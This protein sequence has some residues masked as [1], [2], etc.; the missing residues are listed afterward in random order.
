[1]KAVV[2]RLHEGALPPEVVRAAAVVHRDSPKAADRNQID[3]GVLEVRTDVVP[4]PPGRAGAAD[5]GAQNER[6]PAAELADLVVR[7]NFGQ[8]RH[9]LESAEEG[10]LGGIFESEPEGRVIPD[11]FRRQIVVAGPFAA[12]QH[13]LGTR[14]SG[15]LRLWQANRSVNVESNESRE[16]CTFQC[17]TQARL[18]QLR[19]NSTSNAALFRGAAP[20]RP[21][22]Q[23]LPKITLRHLL[24]W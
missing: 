10:S 20:H 18:Q 24:A 12:P 7:A 14:V 19:N 21:A 8:G 23:T 6:A 3:Q 22:D 1:M 2:R 17:T 4:P 5:G 13:V 15:I 16:S 11:R 9:L